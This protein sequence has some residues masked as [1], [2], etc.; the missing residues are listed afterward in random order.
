MS[1][2]L[3]KALG[4]QVEQL[5]EQLD[6]SVKNAE[7]NI[8]KNVDDKIKGVKDEL[9]IE[10]K[11]AKDE[12][13]KAVTEVKANEEEI[14]GVKGKLQSIE[15]KFD[16]LD[17]KLNTSRIFQQEEQK[18]VSFGEALAKEVEAKQ[19]EIALFAD[20][21]S[22]RLELILKDINKKAV[23]DFS[24]AN[25]TGST[26]WGAQ[27]RQ[28]IIMAPNV[29]THVRQLLPVSPAGP[30]TDYYFMRE[31][32]AGEGSIAFTAEKG[33]TAAT[34]QATGLKPQFD[35][36]L[37]EASVKF[38]TLAGWMAISR[39]A[40]KN[41][42]GLM[43][44]LNRRVPEKMMDA[45]DAAILYGNGTS[46]NIK[47]ILTSGNYVAGSA[48]GATVLVEKIINDLSTFEDTYRRNATG[49][50][51]RPADYYTFFKNKSA[52]SGE[53]DLPQGVVF[54][55]GVLYILGIPVAKVHALNANDY[56]IGDWNNGA[57]L[58]IQESMRIEF[59]EQ[60]GTNVRTNQVTLRVEETVALP[61]YG[62]DYFMLGDSAAA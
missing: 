61:V 24:A 29:G 20:G 51:M 13:T 3:I 54:V 2:K 8:N 37:V 50:A 11:A 27:A 34:T 23:A 31:N 52:G 4:D 59:F 25:L 39:R 48:A 33:A 9:T 49:I 41:I 6:V 46:P 38:E 14:S 58:L 17:K 57:E 62:P 44:F 1:E 32:G 35:L 30:G 21:R 55:N 7:K 47:G 19:E 22:K 15:V 60:D 26:N 36:D 18:G 43:S 53:Y 16:E 5:G 12:A 10:V 56:V 40:M 45:E 42:P 28:G